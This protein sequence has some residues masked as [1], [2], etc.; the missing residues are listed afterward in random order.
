MS[1]KEI[2]KDAI[3]ILDSLS[4]H[5]D[6]DNWFSA[7]HYVGAGEDRSDPHTQIASCGDLDVADLIAVMGRTVS[8]LSVIMQ[9][10]LQNPMVVFD[11]ESYDPIAVAIAR[12]VRDDG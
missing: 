3:A 5:A 1:D 7:R 2:L 4:A 6:T 9:Q 12:A 11:G 8:T 10:A